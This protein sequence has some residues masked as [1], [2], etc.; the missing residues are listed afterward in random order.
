MKKKEIEV[1]GTYA[2]KVS[3]RVV[4]VRILRESPYGGW[5]AR[6]EI[7][8]RSVRVRSAQ[9]L[10]FPVESYVNATGTKRWRRVGEKEAA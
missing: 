1:G 5:D 3:D 4:P 8:G 10:R 6:N 7:T 9:R 2:A